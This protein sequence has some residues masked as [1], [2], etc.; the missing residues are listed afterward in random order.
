MSAHP[1]WFGLAGVLLVVFVAIPG[2]PAP[3][4]PEPPVPPALA[5]P[6]REA[7][8]Q[9]SNSPTQPAALA[10]G[11]TAGLEAYAHPGAL[12]VAGR[13][14]FA[15]A[16]FDQVAAAGGTV[17][18]YIDPVIDNAHGRYHEMLL[19]PSRCGPA[20]RTW[21]G[22]PRANEWGRL[23][24][25]RIGGVLQRKLE[26]VLETMVVENPGMGGFFADD[27]GSRSHF[28]G[29]DW[30]SW[31]R[32]DQLAYRNGAIVLSA[33]LRRVADRHGLIVLVNG[34]WGAGGLPDSGGGYPESGRHGNALADGGVIEHHDREV[35]YF[36]EYACSDQW[37]A[38]SATTQ[39]TAFH[40]AITS[41]RA[42][43]RAYAG[44]SCVAYAS[45]QRS[46]EIVP[47]PWSSFWPNGLSAS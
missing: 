22:N 27:V 38:Y 19:R 43:L 40:L 11:S 34:T 1:W 15:S 5:E 6:I 39:G 2:A 8:V 9:L 35:P 32:T 28:P 12:V 23:A 37:A 42:G 18:L 30:D 29:I 7:D 47:E 46:Y 16:A 17:L 14:N 45:H 4:A 3:P 20:V 31:S 36:T 13:D 24:D 21:P 25:F 26:C 10:Y 41:T 33:T 44:T